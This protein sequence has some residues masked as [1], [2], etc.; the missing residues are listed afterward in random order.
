[1]RDFEKFGEFITL[2]DL[3]IIHLIRHSGKSIQESLQFQRKAIEIINDEINIQNSNSFPLSKLW[4]E[5][6]QRRDEMFPES[7]HLFPTLNGNLYLPGK[8]SKRFR[9]LVFQAGVQ[10]IHNHPSDISQKQVERLNFL[11]FHYQRQRYQII[12]T[13][14]LLDCN[15]LRSSE[16]ANL[17]KRDINLDDGIIILEMTKGGMTQ[18]V[19]IPEYLIEPLRKFTNYLSLDDNLFIKLNG[20]KWTRKDI[21]R[22]VKQYGEERGV[23][24]IYPR[25]IR[26]TIA[27][28]LRENGASLDEAREFLRH[29]ELRTTR[30]YYAPDTV[31]SRR[32][33]FKRYHPRSI[34]LRSE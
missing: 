17:R 6:L 14:A 3:S 19:H 26:T 1:M 25:R 27:R 24:D 33:I 7:E 18:Y 11:R 28:N 13:M 20:N 8:F 9:K 30:L 34:S 21:H 5:F 12:L 4:M 15:A 2:R 23:K 10:P 32:R 29:S 31:E 22:V 16:V